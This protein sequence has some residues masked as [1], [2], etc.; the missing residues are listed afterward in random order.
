MRGPDGP[1]ERT[2][3]LEERLDRDWTFIHRE[4]QAADEAADSL[5]NTPEDQS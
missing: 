2:A 3:A 4:E 1:E 5:D